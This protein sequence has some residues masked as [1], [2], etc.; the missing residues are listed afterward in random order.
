MLPSSETIKST[1]EEGEDIKSLFAIVDVNTI[2]IG[3]D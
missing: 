2:S 3:I 1:E